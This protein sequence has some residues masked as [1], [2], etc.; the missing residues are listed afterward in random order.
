MQSFREVAAPRV[1]VSVISCPDGNAFPIGLQASSFDPCECSFGFEPSD[2]AE[3]YDS[4]RE[5]VMQSLHEVA[6]PRVDVSVV[7]Y[8]DGKTSQLASTVFH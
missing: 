8:P 4:A 1:E 6:A 7:S 2:D 3:C 5:E